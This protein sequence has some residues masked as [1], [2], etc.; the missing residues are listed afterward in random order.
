MSRDRKI[1]FKDQS[2][3]NSD[4]YNGFSSYQ[5]NP[6]VSEDF[7]PT[8]VVKY[9][10]K[11]SPDSREQFQRWDSV[12]E[13]SPLTLNNQPD[14][15]TQN[16]AMQLGIKPKGKNRDFYDL[17]FN[18]NP[19]FET[20]IEHNLSKKRILIEADGF[21]KD[22]PTN[23]H[24]RSK[25]SLFEDSRFLVKIEE[26][27][28]EHERIKFPDRYVQDSDLLMNRQ[29][30]REKVPIHSEKPCNHRENAT[31]SS[32]PKTVFNEM[33]TNA[34][35]YLNK[36]QQYEISPK[37]HVERNVQTGCLPNQDFH[38]NIDPDKFMYQFSTPRNQGIFTVCEEQKEG[39]RT[40][41]GKMDTTA[42]GK[43][44]RDKSLNDSFEVN[45]H[46]FFDRD[47]T[48]LLITSTPLDIVRKHIKVESSPTLKALGV[49]PIGKPVDKFIS[50][51]GKPMEILISPVDKLMNSPKK[52]SQEAE[53]SPKEILNVN[54]REKP[55]MVRESAR[56]S[57]N[58]NKKPC[59]LTSSSA[60]V[61]PKCFHDLPDNSMVLSKSTS[62]D[63]EN[64]NQRYSNSFVH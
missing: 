21:G 9:L 22:F 43:D 39:G 19:F 4:T 52:K 8:P 15:V 27:S 5:E 36:N 54:L 46:S 11:D 38:Q 47:E 51:V 45:K 7:Q 62:E 56:S 10:K 50:P 12:S 48:S 3:T 13:L 33:K 58:I 28:D 24:H 60:D 53:K 57:V 42:C 30:N 44:R 59:N 2:T 32:F 34:C 23:F 1:K 18:R 17:N 49:S 35:D 20:P 64:W 40:S 25:R 55:V 41:I 6:F 61:S 29:Y 37:K 26:V 16:N 63:A 14:S 31:I